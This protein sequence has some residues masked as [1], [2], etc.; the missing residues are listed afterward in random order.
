MNRA[1]RPGLA[2][3]V[4]YVSRGSADGTYA[5]Q[6]RAAV[7]TEI[8]VNGDDW[9]SLCVMNPTGLFFDQR[10]SHDEHRSPGTFHAEH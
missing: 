6:C 1:W 10:V 4:H 9:A 7:V 5:P 3:T 8:G 2:T